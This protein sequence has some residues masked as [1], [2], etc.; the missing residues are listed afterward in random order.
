MPSVNGISPV[1]IPFQPIPSKRHSQC[2]PSGCTGNSVVCTCSQRT[3]ICKALYPIRRQ[4]HRNKLQLLWSRTKVDIVSILCGILDSASCW[5]KAMP[6]VRKP[7][8]S[9]SWYTSDGKLKLPGA[10][11]WRDSI[12]VVRILH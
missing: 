10:F 2:R 8:H 5:G 11:H 12:F 7:T 4:H 6:K 1:T 9:G 3:G